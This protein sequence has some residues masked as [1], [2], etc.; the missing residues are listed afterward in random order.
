VAVDTHVVC[1]PVAADRT[2][3]EV[4]EICERPGRHRGVDLDT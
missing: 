2:R 1:A 4:G 3:L